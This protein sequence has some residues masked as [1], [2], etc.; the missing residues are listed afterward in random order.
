MY[1]SIDHAR[2]TLHTHKSMYL[3]SIAKIDLETVARHMLKTGNSV[4]S[5]LIHFGVL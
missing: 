1:K 5:E 2:A 4:E 3:F